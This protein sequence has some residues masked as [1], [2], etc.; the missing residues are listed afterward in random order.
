M[1]WKSDLLKGKTAVITGCNRGIGRAILETFAANG[2]HAFACVRQET[3]NILQTA[4][5]LSDQYSVE[6]IPVYFDLAD[7][8]QIKAGIKEVTSYKKNIDILVNN[9]G[10]A[11]GGLLQM[12][13]IKT[14][15][16]VFEINYFSQLLMIQL[17]SKLMIRQKSGSIINIASVAGIDGD[18]GYCAYGASKSALIFATKSLSKELAQYH[19]RVNGIAPGLCETDMTFLMESKA[20]DSMISDCAMGRLGKPRE[21]AEAVLFL[22]SDLSS[23]I[24]GQIIRV[25]GGI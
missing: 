20:R 23:F 11:H 3:A 2:A 4:R 17:I 25:D 15:R 12:T 19:I 16:G 24:T 8:N 5:E 13:S 1:V 18:A 7:D 21:I 9:A 6:I 10:V 22:A 14:I